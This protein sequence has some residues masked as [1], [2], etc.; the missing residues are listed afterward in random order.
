MGVLI[1]LRGRG[2]TPGQPPEVLEQALASVR[3]IRGV[4]DASQRGMRAK[5]KAYIVPVVRSNEHYRDSSG[6]GRRLL[7]FYKGLSLRNRK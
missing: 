4:A 2:L 5:Y 6:D 3:W 1:C 7:G